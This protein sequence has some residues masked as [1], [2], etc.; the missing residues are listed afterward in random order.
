VK[1]CV[2]RVEIAIVAPYIA[3]MRVLVSGATGFVGR[4]ILGR[5]HAAG[6]SIRIIARTPESPPARA[7][8][9]RFQAEILPGDL[10]DASS[11][12]GAAL[13]CDAVIHLAGII[14][15]AGRQTFEN[16]H[17]HATENV[18]AAARRAGTRRFIH[19]SALGTRP[20][21][22]SRYHQTKWAAEEA[23]RASG[24]DWTIFRPSLVFG[25]GDQFVNLFAR[26]SRFSPVLPVMGSATVI[27]Q[28]V[29]V[30]D[31]AS[32]F[33]QSIGEPAAR[34][35]VFDLCGP[36]R[37]T[38]PEILREILRV[39]GRRRW[40]VR[41]PRPVARFQAAMLEA[42]Y[43]TLLGKAPPLNRDQLLMLLEDNVGNPAPAWDLFGIRPLPF[44]EGIAR[45][46]ERR[47]E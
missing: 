18:L 3:P 19:M 33:V 36:E 12:A 5:L 9:E 37:F 46:L 32:A 8:A 15:E 16:I 25:P 28:P 39:C 6:Y 22:V 26:M 42:V 11:L 13:H 24:L 7:A 14:S 23:V 45:Y 43:P 34:G 35:R 10:L 31:V 1:A 44:G 21:A 27:L 2:G 17:L 38:F 47:R 20:D 29:S 41:M 30:D 40:I 4:E